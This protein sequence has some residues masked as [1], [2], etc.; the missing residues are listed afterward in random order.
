LLNT[1]E[2][3]ARRGA[4]LV[5]QIVQF[6]RGIKGDP[7]ALQIRH[8]LRD[9]ASLVSNTFSRS[10]ELQTE[11]ANDLHLVMGDATQLHQVLLNL[12]VNARDAMPK[13][14]ILSIAAV[15][16]MLDQQ[17]FGG[18]L[19][20]VSGPYVWFS[21]SDTG[22]GIPQELLE[23]IFEP[24]FTTKAH[25]KGTGLGLSTVASIVRNHN[26]FIEVHSE[27]G[28]GSRFN[29]YLPAV[30]Q[31]ETPARVVLRAPPAVGRGER[32]L[33]VDDELA[34]L[35]MMRGMLEANQYK[36]FSAKDG[37]EALTL[38]Y[39]HQGEIKVIVTDLM[40]P[41]MDGPTLIRAVR[42]VAPEVRIVCVS[43]LSSE[44]KLADLNPEHVNAHLRKPFSAEDLLVT[45][46]KVLG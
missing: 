25:G 21:V 3:S 24:F 1:V 5:N 39:A 11:A 46:R 27:L 18:H 35:E 34:L 19:T 15:N 28:K 20:A 41:V 45:L 23:K 9:V 30:T 44:P 42:Q 38:F 8:L 29:I 10:I 22:T 43:G 12:C 16:I 33:L 6:A 14:G 4:A 37:A 31:P 40:M 32:V 2:T 36:V 17:H 26:G 13:G 7:V